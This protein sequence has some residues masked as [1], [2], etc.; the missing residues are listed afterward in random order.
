MELRKVSGRIGGEVKRSKNRSREQSIKLGRKVRESEVNS[1]M[2]EG[3]N[4][5]REK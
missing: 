5:E 4:R 1:G 2:S 3:I